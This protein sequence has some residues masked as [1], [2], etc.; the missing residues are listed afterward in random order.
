MFKIQIKTEK[1]GARS[2]HILRQNGKEIYTP[3]FPVGKAILSYGFAY[4]MELIRSFFLLSEDW[5]NSVSEIV[6]FNYYLLA[7]WDE[8]GSKKSAINWGSDRQTFL[9]AGQKKIWRAIIIY[10]KTQ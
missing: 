5:D 10:Y 9:G 1:C 8:W 2:I 3:F 7:L 4:W 6:C